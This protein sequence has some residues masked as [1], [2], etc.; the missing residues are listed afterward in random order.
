VNFSVNLFERAAAGEV[1]M[2]TAGLRFVH[3]EGHIWAV[4][5]WLRSTDQRPI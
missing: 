4:L 1:R 5:D 3:D 2:S